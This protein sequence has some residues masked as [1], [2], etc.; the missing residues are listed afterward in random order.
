[1]A[2]Q[3]LALSVLNKLINVWSDF[4]TCFKEELYTYSTDT[5]QNKIRVE[6]VFVDCDSVVSEIKH[7]TDR[8]ICTASAEC[9]HFM[10]FVQRT[11]HAYQRFVCLEN[12]FNYLPRRFSFN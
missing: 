6:S 11:W 9:I 8:Q 2:Y 12:I 1:M 3:L 4:N 7:L 5:N 10:Q